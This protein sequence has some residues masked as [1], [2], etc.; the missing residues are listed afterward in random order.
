MAAGR[1]FHVPRRARLR[2]GRAIARARFRIR[3]WHHA[4][5]RTARVAPRQRIARNHSGNHGVF[6]GAAPAHRRQGEH[7]CARAPARL[8]RLY[9]RQAFRRR[10]QSH[11]R[12][13]HRRPVHLDR[14]YARGPHHSL[15]AAQDRGGRGA[16]Q[17]R[18]RQ[19]FGQSSGQCAGALSARRI[20]PGRRRHALPILAG[21]SAARRASARARSGAARPLRPFRVG[22][23]LCAARTLRQ[24]DPRQDRRLSGGDLCRPRL[25]LLSVFPG[26]AAGARALHHRPLRRLDAAGGAR[27]ARARSREYHTLLDGWAG[28]RACAGQCAG[29]GARIVRAL[30]RRLQRRLPRSLMRPAWRRATSASWK[31]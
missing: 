1:Q 20:V 17:F 22:D 13:P 4:L 30:P 2:L 18:R 3:S 21:D 24:R 5:A 7:P 6:A 14:L 11:R 16:R 9:R 27:D 10:R 12:A 8:S 19:S 29:Q 23:G 26:R 28:R 25:G 15:S 31:D